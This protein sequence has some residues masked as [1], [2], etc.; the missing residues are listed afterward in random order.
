MNTTAIIKFRH[1]S[2]LAAYFCCLLLFACTPKSA[3]DPVDQGPSAL[4]ITKELETANKAVI[5]HWIEARNTNDQERAISLWADEWQGKVG[6]GFN[7]TTV[8]FPDVNI[9]VDEILADSNKITLRW[10]LTGTH[11]GI[12]QDIEPTGKTVNWQGIDIYTMEAGKIADIK[13]A[14]DPNALANQLRE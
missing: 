12:Y 11:Q 13:R 14:A 6:Q 10:T 9:Q 8:S 3:N 2:Y 1:L 7:G 5:E 4:Q